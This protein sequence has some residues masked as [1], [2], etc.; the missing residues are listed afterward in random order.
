MRGI[1]LNT[2]KWRNFLIAEMNHHFQKVKDALIKE[3]KEKLGEELTKI[4][5]RY[6][7]AIEQSQDLYE[8]CLYTQVT[9]QVPDGD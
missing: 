8:N 9:V 2:D 1:D 7:I 4:A 6:G 3:Y 5:L